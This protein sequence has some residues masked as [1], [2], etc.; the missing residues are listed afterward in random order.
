MNEFITIGAVVVGWLLS[1]LSTYLRGGKAR[2]EAIASA[3]SVLLEVRFRALCFDTIISLLKEHGATENIAYQIRNILE[4]IIPEPEE[5]NSSY[6]DSIK[7]LS[8]VAPLVAYEFRSKNSFMKF[9]AN[10]RGMASEHGMD[11]AEIESLERELKSVVL[12]EFNNMVIKLAELH[13]RA[14]A[15]KVKKLVST[16]IE[17]PA[18]LKAIMQ[19]IKA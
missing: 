9:L 19:G 8:K 7:T 13:S 16:N 5:I 15:K 17:I 10:W 4:K 18:E 1:E 3:L 11:A 12:P 14:S 6:D 2:K